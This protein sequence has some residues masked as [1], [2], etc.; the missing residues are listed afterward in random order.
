MFSLFLLHS[1]FADDTQLSKKDT[2]LNELGLSV[3]RI[4]Y[5]QEN[6]I[7]RINE[8]CKHLI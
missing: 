6:I 7:Q 1:V 3:V 8:I 2:L 4:K 5:P